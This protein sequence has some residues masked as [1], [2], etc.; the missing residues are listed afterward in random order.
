MP[1]RRSAAQVERSAW[2]SVIPLPAQTAGLCPASASCASGTMLALA[3]GRPATSH[4][5]VAPVLGEGPIGWTTWLAADHCALLVGLD[6]RCDL[7]ELPEQPDLVEPV[8]W[9]VG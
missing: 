7:P 2:D 3:H 9:A 4:R 5:G 1:C 8:E 6:D